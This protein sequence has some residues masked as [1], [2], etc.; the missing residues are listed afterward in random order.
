MTPQTPAKGIYIEND[1][2][3]CVRYKVICDCENP[4]HEHDVWVEADDAGVH[5]QVFLTPKSPWH[6][7]DRFRQI[8]TLLTQGYLKHDTIISFDEQTALNY[9]ETLKTAIEQAK[10]FRE[11]KND[12]A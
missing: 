4:D 8:W 9:A 12:S 11:N 6:S 10:K 1:W 2:G 5:V 3:D 7:M